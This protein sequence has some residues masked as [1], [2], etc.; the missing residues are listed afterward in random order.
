MKI[1]FILGLIL[2]ITPVLVLTDAA[3]YIL[4]D[5]TFIYWGNAADSGVV[6]VVKCFLTLGFAAGSAGCLAL[7]FEKRIKNDRFIYT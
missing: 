4:F 2:A 6:G 1:F 5:S 7:Y 3:R